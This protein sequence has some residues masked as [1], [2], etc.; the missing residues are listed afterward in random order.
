MTADGAFAAMLRPKNAKAWCFPA[1]ARPILAANAL[2]VC[3]ADP[4][5]LTYYLLLHFSLEK[6]SD[7]PAKILIL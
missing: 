4:S 6:S 7:I 3:F 1:L 5:V 2:V